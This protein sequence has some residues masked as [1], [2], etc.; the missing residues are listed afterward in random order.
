VSS[1]SPAKARILE[2]AVRLIRRRGGADVS[3]A[4]IAKAAGISRQALYLHF[5]DR[6][7]LLLAVVHYVD[8][9]RGLPAAVRDILGAPRGDAALRR[10]VTLQARS[11]PGL[12]ALARAFDAVRRRDADAER[13]WQDRK[14]NRLRG[15]RHIVGQL[16]REGVL[17][18][19][20]SASVAADLLWTLTSLRTWEDLV[21]E[22]GWTARQYEQRMMAALT[23]LLTAKAATSN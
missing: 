6:A 2:T 4:Q 11:N 23:T 7:A 13:S 19:D 22:R 12:W 20:L 15:A 9:R 17:R 16:K 21:L 8:D 10:L 14:A 5:P 1:I 3:M 18:R